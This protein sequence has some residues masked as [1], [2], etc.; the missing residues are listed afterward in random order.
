MSYKDNLA[1][2]AVAI[3]IS[4]SQLLVRWK[5]VLRQSHRFIKIHNYSYEFK[6]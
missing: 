5:V 2:D 3:F 1:K 6:L 4:I